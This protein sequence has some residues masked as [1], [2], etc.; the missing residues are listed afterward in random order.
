MMI[1]LKRDGAVCFFYQVGIMS[2]D[3]FLV[4]LGGEVFN[5]LFFADYKFLRCHDVF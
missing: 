4:N 3:I 2:W 5:L 1:V